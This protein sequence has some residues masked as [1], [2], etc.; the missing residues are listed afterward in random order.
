MCT[1]LHKFYAPAL[2]LGKCKVKLLEI[3]A[4]FSILYIEINL[5]DAITIII[6]VLCNII[7]VKTLNKQKLYVTSSPV[8]TVAFLRSLFLR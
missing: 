2:I 7:N 6:L 4:L 8:D 1:M 5:N 3:L